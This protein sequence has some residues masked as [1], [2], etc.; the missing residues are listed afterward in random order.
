[1]RLHFLYIIRKKLVNHTAGR[2]LP[3]KNNQSGSDLYPYGILF[4]HGFAAGV[5][6]F[7]PDFATAHH[8][9]LPEPSV[10][11]PP[12]TAFLFPCVS[13][14]AESELSFS[15]TCRSVSRTDQECRKRR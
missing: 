10:T 14:P 9:L 2:I 11:G 6:V 4:S 15:R 13:R 5:V 3:K 8:D 1:M 7:L 12:L